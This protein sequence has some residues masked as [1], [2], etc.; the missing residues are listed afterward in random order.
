M[1]T[2]IGLIVIGDEIL[3]GKRQDKHVSALIERLQVRG[4]KLAWVR[5]LGDDRE[6]LVSEL[7]SSFATDDIVFCCGGI[8]STPDDHTRQAVAQALGLPLHMH[9][10]AKALIE[11]RARDTN[12]P[13][14]DIRLRMAE[15]AQGSEIIPNPYN[16][17]AGFFIK[18]HY[19][20]PGFPVMAHPMFEWVL[21]NCLTHLHFTQV[22]KSL[23][24]RVFGT[25]EAMLTEDMEAIE[26][27]FPGVTVFS[28][29][30]VGDNTLPKHIELGVKAT[31]LDFCVLLSPAFEALQARVVA[32]GAAFEVLSPKA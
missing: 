8:G 12:M 4:L 31:G 3:S 27:E 18:R 23:A 25:F 17:I 13:V 5:I 32:K 26:T 10:Q 9:P 30:H 29:P 28:L 21:D 2:R 24:M 19:F 7:K 15:F 22:E 1:A 14:T 20:V 16:K 11:E 6:L